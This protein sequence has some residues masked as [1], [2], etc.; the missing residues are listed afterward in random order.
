MP[1]L[2]R[3]APTSALLSLLLL[4]TAHSSSAATY[5]VTNTN[6]SGPE[7]L[8]WAITQANSEPGP[9]SIEFNLSNCPCVITLT[10]GQLTVNQD[11][12]IT[13][14]GADQL[15]VQRDPS[16]GPFRLFRFN[17]NVTASLSGMRIT[18][19]RLTTFNHDDRFG[20]GILSFASLT[21]SHMEVVNNSDLTTRF[22][23]NSQGA[24]S[25]SHEGEG[26]GIYNGSVLV[27]RNSSLTGN[28]ANR[29][30]RGDPE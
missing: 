29:Y 17:S 14:L 21:L 15:T 12:T 16:A 6:D 23:C 24:C 20:A 26:G 4:V 30:W 10:S 2:F 25:T 11:V 8:R 22:F 13:G 7:S 3:F 19:G 28:S 5:T 18:G 27:I 9:H 1:K